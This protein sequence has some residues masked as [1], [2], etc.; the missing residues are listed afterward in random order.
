LALH[1]VLYPEVAN[2]MN[3]MKFANNQPHLFVNNGSE[4][5]FILGFCQVQSALFCE[6]I[7]IYMLTYQHTV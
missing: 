1:F 3:L 2:G 4:I 6:G 5:S 7:C